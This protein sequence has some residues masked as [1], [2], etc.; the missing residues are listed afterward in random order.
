MA[1]DEHGNELV[2]KMQDKK[3]Y[4]YGRGDWN[5]EQELRIHGSLTHP[6]I[7]SLLATFGDE[8]RSYA[9][10]ERA[11]FGDV[12]TLLTRHG[13]S[14]PEELVARFAADVGSALAYMHEEGLV[15]NDVKPENVVITE[16]E[17]QP[18]FKLC[19]FGF[20][21]ETAANERFRG[22]TVG[23]LSPETYFQRVTGPATDVWSLG[24]SIYGL[25]YGKFPYRQDAVGRGPLK[26]RGRAVSDGLK[27]LLSKML[28]VNVDRR[29]TMKQVLEHPWVRVAVRTD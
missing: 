16:W 7:V 28:D 1:F 10:L 19:D 27:D 18:R 3:W 17:P 26:F 15:H 6:R 24:T 25:L 23:Y 8:T 5:V 11:L 14:I 4:I 20:A 21:A 2:V 22:G 12:C 9:V 13:R 29:V